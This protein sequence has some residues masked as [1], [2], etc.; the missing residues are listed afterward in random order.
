MRRVANASPAPINLSLDSLPV[1]LQVVL[2]ST[3]LPPWL[4]IPLA[5]GLLTLINYPSGV[6]CSF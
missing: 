1:N 2:L 3:T 6:C 5:F 4:E